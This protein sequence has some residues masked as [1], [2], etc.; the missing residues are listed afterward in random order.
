[1]K[2]TADIGFFMGAK[3]WVNGVVTAGYGHIV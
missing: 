3:K 1:M 2:P